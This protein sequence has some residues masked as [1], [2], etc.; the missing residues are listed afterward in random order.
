MTTTLVTP[1]AAADPVFAERYRAIASR[2]RRFDGQFITAVSSTGIYCRPSCP[3]RTPKP[4]NVTFY[5]T[6]AAAHEAG[7]RACKR[8]LPEAVPGTP[9]WDLGHDLSARA[10]RLVADGVVDREGVDGLAAHLGYSARHVHRVLVA[11]LG[12]GPVALARALRAQTAR[13]LLTGTDLRLADVAFAAGFGSV[14]QF[15]DTIIEVFDTTPS[16]LR[17]RARPDRSALPRGGAGSTG[18]VRGPDGAGAVGDDDDTTAVLDLTLPLREPFDAR[19]VFAFLA[20]RAVDGVEVADLAGPVLSYARTLAL[21]HG[22]GAFRATYG[23]PPGRSRGAARFHVELELT[24]VADLP[25]AIARVRRLFDLDADPAAVDAALATDPALT[26]SVHAVP[27]VRVPGAVDATEILVRAL[28]GQQISVAAARTHLSRLAVA[29]GTPFAS[30]FGPTRLFPTPTQ[31]AEGGADHVRGPARRTA[32]VLGVAR[33]LA[34][35]SLALSPA[36]DPAAQSAALEAMPGVGPWTS[37]YVAMRVLHDPDVLLDGDLALRAG[38]A[39]LALPDDRRALAAHAERWAPWRSYAAM[40]LWRAA[41][42]RPSTTPTK[43][44]P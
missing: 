22:P 16:E 35:G 25:A 24:S 15:N 43:E 19:G 4:E 21:P 32:A 8:C 44:N 42:P 27:G 26:A 3:A 34:D 18:V 39:A 36:D 2:D 6:S 13:A 12:A 30:R 23:P 31:L 5:L 29:L 11:E 17:R 7:Y 40:H 28:V 33:A 38:A 20:A 37:G 10:M 9:S 41:A 1:R 14:R